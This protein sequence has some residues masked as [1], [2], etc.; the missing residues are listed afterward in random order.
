[1][2]AGGVGFIGLGQIGRPMAGR[3]A[4]WPGGLWVYDVDPTA[5]AELAADGAKVAN[6]P[7]EVAWFN[8]QLSSF[9]RSGF[10]EAERQ[11]SFLCHCARAITDVP[12]APERM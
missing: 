11:L 3:L 9:S 12:R 7:S 1:M 4:G 6:S 8:R 5:P 10:G 2:S